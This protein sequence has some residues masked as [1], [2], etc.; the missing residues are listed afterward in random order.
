MAEFV[1]NKNMFEFNS[2]AHQQKSGAAI[3]T[4]SKKL[5]IWLI[6]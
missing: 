2:K 1:L 5:L 4:K 6:Y 3:E